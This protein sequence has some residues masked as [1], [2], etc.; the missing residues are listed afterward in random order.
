MATH[1]KEPALRK[2]EGGVEETHASPKKLWLV[3]AALWLQVI[4]VVFV[5]SEIKQP[6]RTPFTTWVRKA[7]HLLTGTN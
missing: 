3:V 6:G 5:V 1:D 2:T 4:V 7:I